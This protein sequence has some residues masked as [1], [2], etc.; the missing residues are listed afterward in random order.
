LTTPSGKRIS[1]KLYD[2]EKSLNYLYEKI[3]ENENNRPIF[4][5]STL[6]HPHLPYMPPKRFMNKVFKGKK[7][8]NM[9]FTLQ[10]RHHEFSNG[11][12]GEA[13]DAVDS[14]QRLYKGELL[15]ADYLIGNFIEK[16]KQENLFDNTILIITSD[17]GEY[18]GEHGL[19][20]HGSLVWEELFNIPCMIRFPEKIAP[21]SEIG[22][23]TSAMD[24]FPTLFGLISETD[25]ITKETMLDGIDIFKSGNDLDDR[26]LVVDSPPAVVPKR[27]SRYPNLLYKVSQITRAARTEKYKYIWQSNGMEYLFAAGDKEDD[28]S[29]I[30]DSKRDVADE[31]K[32]KMESYY[33]DINKEFKMDEYPLNLNKDLTG[34]IPN[35]EIAEELR[36]LGYLT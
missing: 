33:L 7:V 23:M 28:S 5:Y 8:N 1:A 31:L 32:Q 3:K 21:S 24:L 13:D 25:M 11:D 16:L 10:T 30:I 20:T 19:L 6:L 29:N 2:G 15:Y 14:L 27:L 12:Y 22:H 18:L 34:K 9:A 35:P 4:A 17:H 36:K 26:M